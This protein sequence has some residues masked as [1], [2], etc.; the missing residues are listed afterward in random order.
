MQKSSRRLSVDAKRR[1]SVRSAL[2]NAILSQAGWTV[3]FADTLSQAKGDIGIVEESSL[4]EMADLEQITT[5]LKALIILG[6]YG[7][8]LSV[9]PVTKEL[10]VVYVPQP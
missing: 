6:Q 3:S 8:N 1:L 10:D 4:A 9:D 2:S 5:D 7:S